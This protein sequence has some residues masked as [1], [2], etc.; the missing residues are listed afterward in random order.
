[1]DFGGAKNEGLKF[2]SIYFVPRLF[3]ETL[4]FWAIC[5]GQSATPR[6]PLI[7]VFNFG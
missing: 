6:A 1:M 2:Y 3:E 7:L 4:N 5:R